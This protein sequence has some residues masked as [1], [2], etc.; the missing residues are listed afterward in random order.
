MEK[1]YYFIIGQKNLMVAEAIKVLAE[2]NLPFKCLERP[3][4]FT[5]NEENELIAQGFVP[6]Y[7]GVAYRDIIYYD[8]LKDAFL[9]K[10][11]W[12]LRKGISDWQFAV[13]EYCCGNP[14]L[15]RGGA[16]LR[17]LIRSGYKR[18]E[19]ELLQCENRKAMGF[20]AKVE[21]AAQ[22][23]VT[24]AI[25]KAPK[26]QDYLVVFWNFEVENVDFESFLPVLDR[27]FWLQRLM[28]VVIFAK[29]CAFYYGYRG[30]AKKLMFE[31]KMSSFCY[32]YCSGAL[33]AQDE[34]HVANVV[35]CLKQET[36]KLKAEGLLW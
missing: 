21:A 19:I 11:L 35:A 4:I 34:V 2:N 23:A 24:E 15:G 27:V 10:L 8:K 3:Y 32:G 6:Y 1:N 26:Q 20:D 28:N 22:Q 14:T 12:M 18:K 16:S 7:V 31:W 25:A 5:K 33:Y 29:N 13:L 30:I 36:A 9:C 17:D